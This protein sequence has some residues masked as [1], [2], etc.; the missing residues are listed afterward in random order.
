MNSYL[1][2]QSYF[3]N[4]LISNVYSS[5]ITNCHYA[6]MDVYLSIKIHFIRMDVHMLHG[7][8]CI[9][10]GTSCGVMTEYLAITQPFW[11]HFHLRKIFFQL[12]KFQTLQPLYVAW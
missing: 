8:F 4:H 5:H 3:G 9:R 7:Y 12:S 11:L 1:L 2:L 6:H 10:I